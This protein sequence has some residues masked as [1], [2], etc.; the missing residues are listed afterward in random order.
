[1]SSG[2]RPSLMLSIM[3]LGGGGA[4]RNCTLL[5]GGLAERGYPVSL[6]TLADPATDFYPVPQGVERFSLNLGQGST[7]LLSAVRNNRARIRALRE[8]F[9]RERPQG[10][11]SFIDEVNILATLA[12]APLGIP[13]IISQRA[14]T[15]LYDSGRIWSMLRR[16]AY[17]KAARLVSVSHGVDDYFDWIPAGRRTVIQNPVSTAVLKAIE[18]P[19]PPPPARPYVVAMGRLAKQKGFDI[20]LQAFARLAGKH[21]GIDLKILGEGELRSDLE[22]LGSELGLAGRVEFPGR[23]EDPF[24]TLRAATVFVLSSRY[25][26]FPNVLTEAMACGLPVVATDCPAGPSEIIRHGE[27][28]LLVPVEDPDA[29]ASAMDRLLSDAG[30]RQRFGAEA[31]R[32]ATRRTL[33][34]HLDQWEAVIGD[35]LNG[36]IAH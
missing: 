6:A 17:P 29:L 3:S 4:E 22:R 23:L 16:Y 24:P 10:I 28:G 1:M 7:G 21:S 33:S 20:L 31:A 15:D 30:E 9:R 11:I 27:D 8:L 26:G 12:A 34:N 2:D 14:D 18:Q 5:A 13:V 25:E 36:D 19:A 32:I 35:T